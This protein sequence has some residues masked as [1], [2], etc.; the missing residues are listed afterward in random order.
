[1]NWSRGLLRVWITL[2]ILWL[3]VCGI[4]LIVE[5]PHPLDPHQVQMMQEADCEVRRQIRLLKDIMKGNVANLGE[6]TS[7]E[8][9]CLLADEPR[10]LA[11]QRYSDKVRW[12]VIS[13]ASG[14]AI[15]PAVL[16]LLGWAGLWAARGFTQQRLD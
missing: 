1:M 9:Q 11:E 2:T 6:R 5:W 15:P 12:H 3:I 14:A 16:F 8:A 7:E 4:V 10:Q 13:F